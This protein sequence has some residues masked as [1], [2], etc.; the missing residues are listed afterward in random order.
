ML[1]SPPP[2]GREAAPATS[3]GAFAPCPLGGCVDASPRGRGCRTGVQGAPLPGGALQAGSCWGGLRIGGEGRGLPASLLST[4][5]Y[6]KQRNPRQ[7]S[8]HL[9]KE[10]Y[11]SY[12]AK[13]NLLQV[14]LQKHCILQTYN[15]LATSLSLCPGF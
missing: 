2:A 5:N 4:Q 1:S 13:Y 7:L 6:P 15:F 14:R 12:M 11:N 9:S 3:S 10:V 8:P